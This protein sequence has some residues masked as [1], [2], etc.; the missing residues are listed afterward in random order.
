[1]LKSFSKAEKAWAM[2]DWANSAY[3]TIIMAAIFPIYFTQVADSAGLQG[4][5]WWGWGT[6]ASTLVIAVLSPVLGVIGDFKGMKK[7]MLAFFMAVGIIFTLTMAA[8]DE[9]HLMLMGYIISYIGFS[10]SNLF[11]DSLITD[12]T[13]KDRMDRVSTVGYAMGYIGGSTIP[14]LISIALVMFAG[15]LGL[16]DS[17]AVKISVVLTSVWWGLFS[18]P[19]LKNTEQHYYIEKPKH[20]VNEVFQNL[21]YSFKNLLLDKS[22][23]MFVLAYFFFIDGV[24]TVIHMATAYGSTLGLGTNGMIIAL[25]VTQLVA[26]PFS[27]LFGKLADRIPSVRLIFIAICVYIVVCVLGFSMGYIMESAE[28]P[29]LA[30][31]IVIASEVDTADENLRTAIDKA[32]RVQ[33]TSSSQNEIDDAA[34][35]LHK[36]LSK[37]SEPTGYDR[38]LKTSTILFWI[39]AVMVGTVQGG[40]QSVS[41]SYFGKLVP[42]ERSNE[43]FGFFD[44]FGKFA[45]IMGPGLYALFTALTGRASVGIISI[46]FLFIIGG[47]LLAASSRDSIFGSKKNSN[48]R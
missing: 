13:T 37:I 7:K 47:V 31:E 27:I 9:P 20:I 33:S 23:R 45:S 36:A 17:G 41:R 6:S 3:A 2:Y 26:V 42:A 30:D 19:I 43:Y 5:I 1:M 32:L 15:S 24:G 35:E 21:K 10:G 4:S 39:L 16:T 14:F 29:V 46:S 11:Y 25:L 44:I 22:L 28:K 18:I 12:V 34:M 40:I 48:S 8:F 38:A